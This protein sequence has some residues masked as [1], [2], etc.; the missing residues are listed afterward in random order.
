VLPGEYHVFLVGDTGQVLATRTV[1]DLVVGSGI[2]FEDGGQ[3][4]L[5]GVPGV[6]RRFA[7]AG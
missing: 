7:V 6:W 5:K 3:Q 1:A 4:E 2:T